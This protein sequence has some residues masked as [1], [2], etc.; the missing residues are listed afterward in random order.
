MKNDHFWYLYVMEDMRYDS[1]SVLS[2]ETLLYLQILHSLWI[3]LSGFSSLSLVCISGWARI[4]SASLA[5][6]LSG[7]LALWLVPG[8]DSHPAPIGGALDVRHEVCR[9]VVGRIFVW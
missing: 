5:L 3:L 6:W 9:L 7:S 4:W 8:C 2:I 1:L